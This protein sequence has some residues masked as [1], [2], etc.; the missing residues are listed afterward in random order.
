MSAKAVRLSSLIACG[1]TMTLDQIMKAVEGVRERLH[2]AT[3]ALT[4]AKVPYA[5][6]GANAVAAHVARVDAAA[7]RN[8]PNVDVLIRRH[9]ADA[10][11]EAVERVGFIYQGPAGAGIF[12][13]G[14]C[15]S[16]RSRLLFVPACEILRDTDFEA[17]PAVSE[18]EEINGRSVVSLMPLARMKLVQC[19]LID[20]VH[21]HDL[22]D[23]G[24]IDQTWPARLPPAFG[25]ALAAIAR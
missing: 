14:E 2:R 3:A 5:V 1:E 8:T 15:G 9:K 22:I 7:V 17:A 10:A 4:A 18:S 20:R 12:H 19:R 6:V 25:G 11:R 23:V 21:L 13:D 24:L 16:P